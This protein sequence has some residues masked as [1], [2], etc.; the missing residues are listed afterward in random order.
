MPA[1]TRI[2]FNCDLGEGCGNDAAIVPLISSASLA[3]GL[4]AG[5]PLSMREAVELC[6]THDVAIGAHPSLDDREGFGRRNLPLT[7]AQVN[8]LLTRQLDA[9]ANISANAGARLH[10]VKP[11][12]ALYN[13]AVRDPDIA[14]AIAQAVA[15]FDRDLVLYGLSGSAL[16]Q[17]G[18][19]AGL[20]VAHE[21][22]A[23]RRYRADGSLVPRGEAGAVIESVA[24]ALDQVQAML[25]EGVVVATGGERVPIRAETLCLHGDRPDA[26]AFARV[27]RAALEAQG[28]DVRRPE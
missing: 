10:H 7:P 19:S 21:V 13:R 9:L 8:D 4:H 20:R 16:T 27:L 17:A 3:C 2:D 26:A 5:D 25:R 11:H 14:G 28:I 6:L 22:F 23:E 24:E 1:V 15:R 18:Q 12:G